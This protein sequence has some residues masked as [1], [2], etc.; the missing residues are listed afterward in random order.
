MGNE[1]LPFLVKSVHP[2][3]FV[4]GFNNVGGGFN[5]AGFNNN[6][7]FVPWFGMSFRPNSRLS[8]FKPELLGQKIDGETIEIRVREHRMCRES[9]ERERGIKN[10]IGVFKTNYIY[11]YI[12]LKTEIEGGKYNVVETLVIGDVI[13]FI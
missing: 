13:P 5:N 10:R 7:G 8:S 3:D 1:E 9:R 2:S 12:Y 6:A 4:G 11:I